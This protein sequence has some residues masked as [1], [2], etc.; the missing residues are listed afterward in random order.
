MPVLLRVVQD[1]KDEDQDVRGAPL[2]ALGRIRDPR[3]LPGL[4]EATGYPEASLPPRI[5]EI[6][7]MF[8]ADSVPLLVAEL[9]SLGRQRCPLDMGGGDPG[10]VRG[11]A[12][13]SSADRVPG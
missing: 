6:I 13:G 2:R 12:G 3:V 1:I 5:A 7:V 9:R 10:L 11:P 4:I 8:G